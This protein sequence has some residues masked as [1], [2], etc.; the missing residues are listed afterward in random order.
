VARS[1]PFRL[2]HLGEGSE[3]STLPQLIRFAG[4]R[5]KKKIALLLRKKGGGGASARSPTLGVG[6]ER[7]KEKGPGDNRCGPGGLWIVSKRRRD[8]GNRGYRV[9]SSPHQP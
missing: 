5:K 8:E 1:H 4:R 3:I 2:S 6:E 7:E 9:G